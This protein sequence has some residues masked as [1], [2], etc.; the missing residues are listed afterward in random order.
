MPSEALDAVVVGAGPNGLAA[1]IRLAQAG[2]SV[3]VLE[4]NRR[5]GGGLRSDE[6][7]E[8]GFRH[9]ICSTV[10]AM[11]PLSPALK[12]IEF[13][14]VTPPAPLAHPFDDGTAAVVE[15]SVEETA[16]ALGGDG[17]AYRRLLRPLVKRADDL[18]A[19]AMGPLKPPRHPLLLG[20]FG[21]PGLLPAGALARVLFRERDTRA[22]LAGTAAHSMLA[23][24]EPGTAAF[25]LVMLVT[26]HAGGW[27]LARGGSQSVAEALVARL[28]QL[29]GEVRCGERVTSLDHVPE[30][31]AALLDLVP[32]GVL[33][34]AGDRMSPAYRKR[35]QRYRH[36]PAVFK[37]D[38][39]L[40]GPIPW[41]APACARAATVHLG[42]TLEEIAHSEHEVARGRSAERP[43]VILVQ[44][45]LFDSSRAPAGKH[46][47]WAYCH[48]PNG[49]DQDL[50]KA[51]E[52]QVERFAPG[53][54][55]V[56][57]QRRTW[58]P[59]Q[60][61]VEQPNCIGGDI[62]GGRMDLGQLFTRPV[63]RLDPYRTSDPAIFICSA[64][65]P[66]AGGIHGLC[67]WY[68][69]RSALRSVLA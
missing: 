30:H 51:V 46:V 16:E 57:R 6:L 40:D 31:R 38:W 3:L 5:P 63:A 10:M 42:G 8:P 61:Q 32:E 18:V 35:L 56:V 37:V 15:R 47:A 43:F 64:A 48:V 41:R 14:L 34:V 23:L 58:T 26:A 44:P 67:G 12:T 4:A 21:M 17:P 13:D 45:T 1:A 54:R 55:D 28:E 36:G 60:L 11:V 29:G 69:A 25:A 24:S 66:P 49:C 19:D 50:T 52:D 62:S 33:A 20:R 27:P 9:D 7:L 68:A 22:L 65:T 59:A 2:R 39:T 53:F